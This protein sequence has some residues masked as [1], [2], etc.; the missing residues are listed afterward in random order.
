MKNNVYLVILLCFICMIPASAQLHPKSVDYGSSITLSTDIQTI[1]LP[2]VNGDSLKEADILLGYEN[3]AGIRKDVSINPELQGTVDNLPDGGRLWRMRFVSPGA[4]SHSFLFSN[5]YLAQGTEMWVYAEDKDFSVKGPFTSKNNKEYRRFTIG[6]TT[7]SI[8]I[9][10]LYEPPSALHQSEILLSAVYQGYRGSV[11][12]APPL[13]RKDLKDEEIQR[14][15]DGSAG[16]VTNCNPNVNCSHGDDWCREK[17]AVCHIEVYGTQKS[18]CTGTLINNTANNKKTYVLS[19]WHCANEV[20]AGCE[21]SSD[22]ITAAEDWVFVF[23]WWSDKGDCPNNGTEA[24]ALDNIHEYHGATVRAQYRPSDMLLLEIVSAGNESLGS[25]NERF[26]YAG[27]SRSTTTPMSGT[28]L[29]HPKGDIMKIAKC[30][31]SSNIY[32]SGLGHDCADGTFNGSFPSSTDYWTFEWNIG[33]N[34][35]GSSGSAVFDENHLI[36]G[37]LSNA[38]LNQ[39]QTTLQQA[40]F[41]KFAISWVGDGVNASSRLSDWLDPLNQNPTTLDGLYKTISIYNRLTENEGE[42]VDNSGAT[43][44]ARY[45]APTSLILQGGKYWAS[46]GD[47]P[48]YA[49]QDIAFEFSPDLGGDVMAGKRIALKQCVAIPERTSVNE[50]V[51][52]HIDRAPCEIGER[53]EDSDIPVS[54]IYES[55]PMPVAGTCSRLYTAVHGIHDARRALSTEKNNL[56][57][58]ETISIIPNPATDE[59]QILGTITASVELFSSVGLSVMTIEKG[60]RKVDVSQL[61]SGVYYARIPTVTGVVVKS[62]MI[63][64]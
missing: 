16:E 1:L 28:N 43:P 32:S 54:I 11:P 13:S 25:D 40:R 4:V 34:D 63:I 21:L 20:K 8:H 22:E 58:N 62:F 15:F 46:S 6:S 23:K 3:R 64:R 27:W 14:T 37:Q 56:D 31:N 55:D 45:Y 30:T 33:H 35:E 61:T 39:C 42:C 24:H 49:D 9:L 5:F 19:A 50:R 18:I 52:I 17:Y 36:R 57:P 2:S 59:I 60:V 48:V 47:K 26:Y 51:R 10:E 7:G 41:G 12:I 53:A 29:H 44:I 38:T